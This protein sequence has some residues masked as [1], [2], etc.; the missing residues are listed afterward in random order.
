M[1]STELKK[2]DS[3]TLGRPLT[4]L[5]PLIRK[6][7][8]AG[9]AAGLEHYRKAGEMLLE[10][11]EQCAHGEWTAWVERNFHLSNSTALRYMKLADAIEKRPSEVF[12]SMHQAV[13][14]RES[15]GPAWQ[16]PVQKAVNALDVEAIR[17]DF[18][19][20]AKEERL[21]RDLAYQLIDIGYKVLASKLHPDK[22]GSSEAM[23]RLNKV[24]SLLK[25]AV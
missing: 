11:K 15:R 17:A 5:A 20:K 1:A 25:G 4:V 3:G 21:M 16:A 18:Q 23:A 13:R 2:R 8:E 22:G 24:K 19:S 9:D 7:L 6:E 14:P 10:A 12:A